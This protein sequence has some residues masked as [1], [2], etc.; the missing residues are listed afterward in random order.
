[1]CKVRAEDVQLGHVSVFK[2]LGYVLDESG[3]DGG[4]CRMKVA[5]GR[6]VTVVIRPFVDAKVVYESACDCF[7]VGVSEARVRIEKERA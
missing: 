2:Y 6:K 7:S 5:S 1:M 3:T 4:E